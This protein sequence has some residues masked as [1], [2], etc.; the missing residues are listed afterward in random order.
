[1][2]NLTFKQ[3]K[4]KSCIV[5]STLILSA[6]VFAGCGNKT[7]SSSNSL[8][9]STV[10]STSEASTEELV[11]MSNP[12]QS[13]SETDANEI[14]P[15]LF[16]VPEGATSVEWSKMSYQDDPEKND[17]VQVT[18]VLDG[19]EFCARAENGAAESDEIHGLFYEWTV[20]EDTTLSSWGDENS[21]HAK[22]YRSISDEETVDLITWYDVNAHISYSLSVSAKNLD[23]FDIRAVA[24]QMRQ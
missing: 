17:L 8:E 3:K 9:G 23:G 22:L 20:N 16:K 10:E 11:N 5:A 15:N 18:F 6:A 24:D 13:C 2:F 21:I 14:C 19:N 12:W 7:D 1:M 4:I